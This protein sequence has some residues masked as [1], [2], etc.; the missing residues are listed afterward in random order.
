V[1]PLEL[2][3]QAIVFQAHTQM[4]QLLPQLVIK[5]EGK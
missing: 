2:I 3:V 5:W 4:V 1:I